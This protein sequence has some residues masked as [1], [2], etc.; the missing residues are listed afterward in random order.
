MMHSNAYR[1]AP[2]AYTDPIVNCDLILNPVEAL[3]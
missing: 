3:D 2:F 1:G